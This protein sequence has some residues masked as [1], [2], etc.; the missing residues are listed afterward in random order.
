M[1]DVLQILIIEDSALDADILSKFLTYNNVQAEFYRVDTA[2]DLRDILPTKSWDIIFCDYHIHPSFTCPDALAII[3]E[4]NDGEEK[5]GG[6]R[7][8]VIIVS[9]VINESKIVELMQIGAADFVIKGYFERLIPILRR[10]IYNVSTFRRYEANIRELS[11]AL[12][13]LKKETRI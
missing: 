2:Q 8:P 12:D 11:A 7:V 6:F 13:T 5:N 10:E 1:Q 4:H 3:S 9:S